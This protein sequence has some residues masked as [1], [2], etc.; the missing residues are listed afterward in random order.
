MKTNS[1]E[2]DLS[3][4]NLLKNLILFSLPFL[5]SNVIQVVYALLWLMRPMADR[6]LAPAE[7]GLAAHTRTGLRTATPAPEAPKRRV[8]MAP[9]TATYPGENGRRKGFGH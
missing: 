8:E 3:E 7:P 4:G 5:L 1:I 9:V 6:T 2:K